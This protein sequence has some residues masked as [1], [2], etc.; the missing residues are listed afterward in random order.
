MSPLSDARRMMTEITNNNAN[1]YVAGWLRRGASGALLAS[2]QS[3]CRL[4]TSS[5]RNRHCG[6]KQSRRARGRGGRRAGLCRRPHRID[7]LVRCCA[8]FDRAETHLGH[9]ATMMCG[10]RRVS[11]DST[12]RAWSAGPT[13]CASTRTNAKLCARRFGVLLF[14]IASKQGAAL[15]VERVKVSDADALLAIA[16]RQQ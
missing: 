1:C 9:T 16:R 4:L 5:V 7:A 13:G 14:V 10:D 12:P 2:C 8:S 6:D 11:I 15:N 3:P